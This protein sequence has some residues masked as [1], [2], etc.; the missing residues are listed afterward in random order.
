M[1]LRVKRKEKEKKTDKER[2]T[3]IERKDRKFETRH[4]V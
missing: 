1:I 2:K 3:D 4:I